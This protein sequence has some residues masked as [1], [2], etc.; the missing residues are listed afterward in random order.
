MTPRPALSRYVPGAAA[1][2]R[3]P[4][5]CR[6]GTRSMDGGERHYGIGDR[7]P[8][9]EDRRLLTGRGRYAD[10]VRI[11]GALAGYVLR[12]PEAHG[13]IRILDTAAAAAMPGVRLVLCAQ[14]LIDF[15]CR[16]FPCKLPITGRDGAAILTPV[17]H[18]LA[19]GRVRFI[20]EPVAF[21]VADTLD[22]AR[23]AAEAIALEIEP[24]P[25]LLD[26]WQ[27][28]EPDA[29]LLHD[30]VPGNVALDWVGGDETANGDAGLCRCAHVY[31]ACALPA[32]RRA[33]PRS[34]RAAGTGE[35]DA[36]S[37]RYTM[38]YRRAGRSSACRAR[39]RICLAAS[40]GDVRV[41][42]GRCRRSFV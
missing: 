32:K 31:P 10:D 4:F 36:G 20:G 12:A 30:S 2:L 38:H 22:A 3:A 40:L 14:D 28:P 6:E 11:E 21:V 34:S 17:R 13:D 18:A 26:P 1:L 7:A 8:R 15:S 16:P 37:G 33:R 25:V 27:A 19:H 5:A 42:D 39:W 9:K 35:W 41:L 23:D 29:P 24:L